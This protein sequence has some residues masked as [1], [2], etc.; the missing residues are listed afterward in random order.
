MAKK[1]TMT[2]LFM[3]L[4]AT[5][6]VLFWVSPFYLVVSI[7]GTVAAVAL[8]VLSLVFYF[9]KH[10]FYSV[11]LIINI[12]FTAIV[13]IF[14]ILYFTGIIEHFRDIETAREWFSSFGIIAWLVLF[15]IQLLQV[16]IIPI[17]AQVTTIAGVL[18]FGAF[19]CF[20][21]SAA[22]IILGSI[23]C[24]AL[25]R[26]LGVQIAYKVASK[27]TVDKYR[28][29]LEKRGRFLLPIFFLLPCFPDDMLCFVAGATTMTWRYFILTSIFTRTI[30]VACIC[31]LGSGELIPFS[32]WGIPVWIV[33]AILLVVAIVL[34]FKYQDKIEEFIISKLTQKGKKVKTLNE[35]EKE[36][37]IDEQQEI[38]KEEETNKVKNKSKTIEIKPVQEKDK[39]IEVE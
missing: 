32:G 24:F 27:E 23:I 14:A 29:L 26:W 15:I 9:T 25:G 8:F 20:V 28:K 33:L 38:S 1:I 34:L 31:W 17:P 35:Q 6:V 4:L 13:I 3:L 39:S 10:K 11:T 18:I 2:I 30:G 12:L 7:V 36:D 19:Q 16:V 37:E 22:A 21:I 5:S